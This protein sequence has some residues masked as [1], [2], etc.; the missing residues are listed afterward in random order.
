MPDRMV[1]KTC[2]SASDPKITRDNVGISFGAD[3]RLI[4]VKLNTVNTVAKPLPQRIEIT[5]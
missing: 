3:N 1:E 4:G 5:N 2:Q